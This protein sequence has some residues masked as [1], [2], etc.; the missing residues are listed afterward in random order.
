MC[1]LLVASLLDSSSFL[2]LACLFRAVVRGAMCLAVFY[3][4][5]VIAN[6]ITHVKLQ[7]PPQLSAMR[8]FDVEY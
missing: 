6:N 5:E 2:S 1:W 8:A 7:T 3:D 4:T